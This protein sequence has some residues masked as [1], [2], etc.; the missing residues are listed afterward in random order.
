M[1][2]KDLLTDRTLKVQMEFQWCRRQNTLRR[3]GTQLKA[4]S[5][6]FMP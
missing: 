5:G 6:G 3:I 2:H 4:F 1:L